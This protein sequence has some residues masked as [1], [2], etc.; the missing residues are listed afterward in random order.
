MTVIGKLPIGVDSDVLI[1]TVGEQF[2]LQLFAEKEAV[3]PAGS[4]TADIK[5][6]SLFPDVSVALKFVVPAEP[7]FTERSP[8]FESKKL[9]GWTI[10]RLTKGTAVTV[11]V[12]F[13]VRERPS[14][15]AATVR[16]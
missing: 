4:P 2:R 15:I 10:G 11:N 16:G 1:V 9:K 6:D 13:V 8:E 12:K 5:T 14:D 3:A 7:A